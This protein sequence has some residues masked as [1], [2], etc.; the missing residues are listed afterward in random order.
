MARSPRYRSRPGKSKTGTIR[1]DTI[2]GYP[3]TPQ[4][5]THTLSQDTCNDYVGRPVVPSPLTLINRKGEIAHVNGSAKC[6]GIIGQYKVVCSN[7]PVTM[8]TSLDTT[9]LSPPNG[10]MLDLVAGTNPSRPVVTP[11]TL[12]QDLVELPSMLREAGKF[13]QN[14]ASVA[15]PRGAANQ[16]LGVKFGWLPL[17]E[18]INHLM[19]L[20]QHIIKRCAE[21]DKLNSGKGLRRRLKFGEDTKNESREAGFATYSTHTAYLKYNV[22]LKKRSWATITWKPTV[23]PPYHPS[24]A[25]QHQLARRLVLGLTPE[26]LAKGAWDVIPWTWL[27]GWFTNIGKYALAYSNTVPASHGAGCFMSQSDLHLTPGTI[28]YTPNWYEREFIP[29][30]QGYV[31]SRKTRVTSTSVVAGANLPFLDGSRLSVLGALFVQRFKR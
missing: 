1:I 13:L 10:W 22:D 7:Y 2:G 31:V 16:F 30:S 17:I 5:L 23:L 24:D 19:N 4:T 25:D 8:G 26:G 21:L 9:P 20:Q 3:G 14:P 29:S 27:I 15:A 6:P 28:R 18:D 12:L 11:L